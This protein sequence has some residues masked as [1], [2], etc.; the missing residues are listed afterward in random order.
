LFSVAALAV[1]VL[2]GSGCVHIGH[3]AVR[4][5]VWQG[6]VTVEGS[7][8]IAEGERLGILPGTRVLFAFHDENGDGAGDSR[9]VVKGSVRARGTQDA[10]IEFAPGASVTSG[11]AGWDEVLIEDAEGCEFARCRFVGAQQAVH[12]HRTALAVEE[13]RF[14]GNGIGLRFTGGPVVIRR[15]RFV[16]NGTAV[17]YWE[18]DPTVAAN[19]FEGNATA[20]FVREGSAR[21]VITGNNFRSSTDYHIKLGES[22]PAD[23]DARDN[24]WGSARL[25]DIERLIFDRED[26][27]YLGRVRYAPPAP[28]PWRLET[29]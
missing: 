7:V 9:I 11:A 28:G 24:W 15:N 12:A 25:E 19:E 27:G 1:S 17:R 29:F 8:V 14:E 23:V 18:S 13:C 22:Q 21:S 20:V 3:P 16:A 6:E 4:E 26:A 2:G 10:P 5:I